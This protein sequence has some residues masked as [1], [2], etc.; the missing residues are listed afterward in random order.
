MRF[1]STPVV[2]VQSGLYIQ[3]M[4]YDGTLDHVRKLQAN[5][6]RIERNIPAHHISN[7][8]KYITHIQHQK[9]H[10]FV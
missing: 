8:R 7:A 2:V 4:L 3:N 10:P 1:P 6:Q 9:I 5:D